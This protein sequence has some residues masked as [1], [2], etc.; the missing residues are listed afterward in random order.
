MARFDESGWVEQLPET[1]ADLFAVAML[2]IYKMSG[3]DL[4][5][6]QIDA[7]FAPAQASWEPR[8]DELVVWPGDGFDAELIYRWTDG[9][10]IP[11]VEGSAN[12]APVLKGSALLL[13]AVQ[14]EWNT[15]VR[16]WSPGWTNT[17][18]GHASATLSGWRVLPEGDLQPQVAAPNTVATGDIATK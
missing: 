9:P 1:Q 5:A 14:M 4:V 8:R 3:V 7:Q 18:D 17:R 6:E 12:V 2:G 15:W 16:V 11:C 13:R 10:M